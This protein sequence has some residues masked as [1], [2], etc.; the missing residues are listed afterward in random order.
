MRAIAGTLPILVLSLTAGWGQI[1]VRPRIAARP[2]V[3][4]PVAPAGDV[5]F[6]AVVELPELG[7]TVVDRRWVLRDGRVARRGVAADGAAVDVD[8]LRAQDHALGR[9]RRGR[10][11]PALAAA[12]EALDPGEAIDVG[13]WLRAPADRP[14]LGAELRARVAGATAH[15]APHRVRAARRAVHDLA[16][17]RYAADNAAFADA[18]RGAGADV[19]LRADAW[20][21][22]VARVGADAARGLAL[23]PLVD[24]AYLCQPRWYEEGDRAQGTLRT[25]TAWAQGVTTTSAVRV[26]VNDTAHVQSNNP[27]LPNVLLL[28]GGSAGLHATGVAG[29]IANSHPTFRAAS[30]GLPLL[31]SAGGS[32]DVAAP[33][34][35]SLAITQGADFGNCSWWNG[36]KGTI[37]LL[38][39]FFDHTIRNFGVMMF[40]STGNQG[41]SASPYTTTPGNGF[42]MI[43]SGAYSDGDTVA[44]ADD[45]MASSSSYWNPLQGHE[46]PE[47]ASPGTCVT[48]TGTGASA[49]Q[50]CFGGT[51]SA[52]PLTCGVAALIASG[53]PRLLA[54]M[55]TVKAVLMASAWH[56]VQG[57]PVLSDRD[58]VGGVHAAAAWATVRDEQ[59][60][61][62]EVLESDFPGGVLDV[63]VDLRAGDATRVVALWFSNPNDAL[64]TDVLDMDL[65]MTVLGPDGAVL[66]SSVSAFNPFEIVEV[67]PVLTG[68]HTVRL[69]RQRFN[70]L[71]EPLT[72][73]WSSRSDTATARIDLAAG[74]P[75]FDPG[76][77]PVLQLT[78]PYE[79][80]GRLSV[81]WAALAGPS[82]V[83]L[84]GGFTLPTGVDFLSA[85]ALSLTGFLGQL[86][87][88]GRAL[89][90]F[91]LP[92]SPS[93]VGI[94]VHF[95]MVVLGPTG[96]ATDVETVSDDTVLV[97]GG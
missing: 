37:A 32:G 48:T 41:N 63:P 10:M 43:N 73:A 84:A 68:T 24:T 1:A 13:F 22:V 9:S 18:A 3:P 90:P 59:W 44:W 47:L 12:V 57:D 51:S 46:K 91:P 86:D 74:S 83:P 76:R 65:D 54:E 7:A 28:N 70:E 64:S 80:A 19:L 5:V 62:D 87:G 88:A 71:S 26:L 55:T 17:A 14:E 92:T 33:P 31:L 97:I 8:S 50:T 58:G 75:P 49:L 35:W 25:P 67:V 85:Y 36:L 40:K 60:W 4:P 82:G 52:S 23:H 29:N 93:T 72:V 45:A 30:Y 42:N 79:G 78:E 56:N 89:A 96:A 94:S 11:T 27:Y 66:A 61:H 38:D 21:L 53:D 69:T 39:R 95:G 81:A 6:D 15:D 77:V 34:I 20:P 2:A 16:V